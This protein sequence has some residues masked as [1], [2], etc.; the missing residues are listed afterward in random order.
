MH[1]VYHADHRTA[2]QRILIEATAGQNKKAEPDLPDLGE[3]DPTRDPSS[4]EIHLST[5]NP[6]ID[7]LLHSTCTPDLYRKCILGLMAGIEGIERRK[8]YLQ[9]SF[10]PADIQ[11]RWKHQVGG[12]PASLNIAPS[13]EYL[14]YM[15]YQTVQILEGLTWFVRY[16]GG[17]TEQ[18]DAPPIRTPN[19]S[20][21][22][23]LTPILDALSVCRLEV[24]KLA[25]YS[26]DYSTGRKFFEDLLSSNYF[27]AN[28]SDPPPRLR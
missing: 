28:Q 6:E 27:S 11:T 2:F 13:G 15:G 24:R 5:Y 14:T 16:F 17:P 10:S 26:G 20:L 19:A 4:A 7:G 18:G 3:V 9:C 12:T 25:Q 21:G 23:D 8:L 1:S 22:L